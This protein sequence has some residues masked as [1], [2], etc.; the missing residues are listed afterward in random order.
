[1]EST[2]KRTTPHP[3][4][5]SRCLNLRNRAVVYKIPVYPHGESN[6][7]FRTENP[8]SWATR[9]WGR[10]ARSAK[11][12]MGPKQPLNSSYNMAQAVSTAA[13]FGLPAEP[14]A[15]LERA[16]LVLRTALV[17]AHRGLTRPI[18]IA[19]AAVLAA[20]A[21]GGLFI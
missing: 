8:T 12:L 4:K 9:R 19:G 1:M 3:V 13:R 2:R 18:A 15:P 21:F 14:G 6:P 11:G 16:P 5:V 10:G 17:N 7:G 20:L